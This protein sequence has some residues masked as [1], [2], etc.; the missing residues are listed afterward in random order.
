MKYRWIRQPVPE[1]LHV[2][3]VYEHTPLDVYR[4]GEYPRV[5]RPVGANQYLRTEWVKLYEDGSIVA[6]G[7]T[8]AKH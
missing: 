7:E 8:H 3:T 4:Y 5:L 1:T 6:A 2:S